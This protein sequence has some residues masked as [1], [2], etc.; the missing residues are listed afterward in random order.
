MCATSSVTLTLHPLVLFTMSSKR[1]HEPFIEMEEIE[2]GRFE[3]RGE[4][5]K[6]EKILPI[7]H[8]STKSSTAQV[9]IFMIL[10]F[11]AMIGHE[12]ALEAASA[13]FSHLDALASAVTCFQFSFCVLSP[14]ILSGGR[15]FERFPR[16]YRDILPYI[17]LSLL[18]FGATG[19]STQA[20][21]Y[22]TYPTK[23]VMKSAKLIPT[24]IVSSLWQGQKFNRGEYVAAA[25]L[26]TGAAGYSYGS[27]QTNSDS[28]SSTFGIS[29]LVASII[30]DAIVPNYQK[31]LMNQGLSATQLMINVNAV[32]SVA[33]L[34]YMVVTGQAWT[35]ART[36][37]AHPKLLAYLFCVGIGLSTAVW[38][39]T[40]LI[41]ATSSVAA[42][43]VAT[44][45]KVA[46]MC[47]SY[48]IFPKPLLTIHIYS[49]VLVLSGMVLS[50]V[51]KEKKGGI[52]A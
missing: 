5:E 43:T 10:F 31:L 23:V 52:R 34:G 21:R 4:S 41:Q 25:L 26:C 50:T 45:R 37:Q 36:C 2:V 12:V 35:I 13:S 39:Y 19:L 20:V 6:K 46:T 38:A 42:V 32:G 7:H 22:V 49:G 24:M 11:G 15:G 3:E 29:L 16:T 1:E 47:L 17:R 14:L 44:L 30:C 33:V 27:G 48:I 8:S 9:I 28:G 51:M 18:V 40:R